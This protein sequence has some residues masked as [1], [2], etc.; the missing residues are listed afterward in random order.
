MKTYKIITR[1]YY[2]SMNS[3]KLKKGKFI[4]EGQWADGHLAYS[5]L[6]EN[7]EPVEEDRGM[8]VQLRGCNG[9]YM[10]RI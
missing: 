7:D 1:N 2:E 4:A 8:F 6:D 5:L 9:L 3:L 10:Q